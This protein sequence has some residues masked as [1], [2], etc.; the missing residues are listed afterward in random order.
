MYHMYVMDFSS[1]Q[2][3]TNDMACGKF[4]MVEI[5]DVIFLQ[6]SGFSS[7]YNK[8]R[9]SW[10]CSFLCLLRRLQLEGEPESIH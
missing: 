2:N 7:R 1:L 4:H 3:V 6:V 10:H 5:A 8:V 9:Q